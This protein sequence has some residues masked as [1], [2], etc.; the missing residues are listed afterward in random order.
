MNEKK[1]FRVEK[2]SKVMKYCLVFFNILVVKGKRHS[3]KLFFLF[4]SNW[5]FILK[6][7]TRKWVYLK[8]LINKL[9]PFLLWQHHRVEQDGVERASFFTILRSKCGIFLLC[10]KK[11]VHNEW[12]Q[13]D[14]I[15]YGYFIAVLSTRSRWEF[16]ACKTNWF[17]LHIP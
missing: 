9:T 14:T 2:A 16:E 6:H 10:K 4:D 17:E 12:Q 7:A 11:V 13:R 8:N 1:Y 3:K 15:T 5:N